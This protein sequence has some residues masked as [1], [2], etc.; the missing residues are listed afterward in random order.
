MR[1]FRTIVVCFLSLSALLAFLGIGYRIVWAEAN[2][3]TNM[4]PFGG[5]VEALAIDPQ[6]PSTVYAGTATGLFKSTD[7]GGSWSVLKTPLP[8]GFGFLATDPQTPSTVY[9]GNGSGALKSID[10]GN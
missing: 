9:V 1:A 4:G 6:N 10:G 5:D 8:G 3:W 7:G 2:V